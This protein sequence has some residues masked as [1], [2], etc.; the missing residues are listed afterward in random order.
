[1]RESQLVSLKPKP[2]LSSRFTHLSPVAGRHPPREGVTG[3]FRLDALLRCEQAPILVAPSSGPG[4]RLAW[5]SARA[6]SRPSASAVRRSQP[7]FG[8]RWMHGSQPTSAPRSVRDRARPARVGTCIYPPDVGDASRPPST[9]G[10]IEPCVDSGVDCT[11]CTGTT[12]L[13]AA[14]R[15]WV[16]PW[17]PHR[18]RVGENRANVVQPSDS[19]PPCAPDGPVNAP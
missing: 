18:E 14:V 4:K 6:G 15:V 13:G 3:Q 17:R 10:V 2:R 12:L 1:V 16:Q 11:F 7:A 9:L 19:E 8:L 5:R